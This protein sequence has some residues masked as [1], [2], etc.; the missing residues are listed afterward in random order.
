MNYQP[1]PDYTPRT[2]D[3]LGIC[4]GRAIP[5]LNCTHA[6]MPVWQPD[7]AITCTPIERMGYWLTVALL[8]T[9]IAAAV[10]G[11]AGAAGY[12]YVR[13]IA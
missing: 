12:V 8:T 11:I 7:E 5:C 1:R 4:Q 10:V 3:E 2:C 13:F 6:D 9:G